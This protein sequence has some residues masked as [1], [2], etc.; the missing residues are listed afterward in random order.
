[1]P[2]ARPAQ[3][4]Q[5]PA[6]PPVQQTEEVASISPAVIDQAALS[7]VTEPP[8][9][10]AE[11]SATMLAQQP[12]LVEKPARAPRSSPKATAKLLEPEQLPS[13]TAP[14]AEAPER[15]AAI[16]PVQAEIAK[17]EQPSTQATVKI[18][19]TAPEVASLDTQKATRGANAPQVLVGA[20]PQAPKAQL[21][22]E[23]VEEQ[24]QLQA[25]RDCRALRQAFR[26]RTLV[27]SVDKAA[28]KRFREC[29]RLKID[30]KQGR[31]RVA[32][33]P[34]NQGTNQTGSDGG[35]TGGS[36]GGTSSGPGNSGGKGNGKGKNK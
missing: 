33:K 20:E 19:A 26:R 9:A 18:A 23:T 27:P 31:M 5:P 11:G 30:Q 6:Q 3:V 13:V 36:T 25:L 10:E 22:T 17:P 34:S 4:S 16:S 8:A 24:A 1:M 2:K 7:V 15:Q 14:Q 32:G 12:T 29:Q 28:Y 21:A 35:A